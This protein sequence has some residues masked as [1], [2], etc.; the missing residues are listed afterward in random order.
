PGHGAVLPLQALG[1]DGMD[2]VLD[3][4]DDLLPSGWRRHPRSGPLG[5]GDESRGPAGHRT[6]PPP[7]RAVHAP[8]RTLPGPLAGVVL[9]PSDGM[10]GVGAADRDRSGELARRAFESRGG[11]RQADEDVRETG[12]DLAEFSAVLAA[13]ARAEGREPHPSPGGLRP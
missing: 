12:E 1:T 6:N 13:R 5:V 8:A 4:A 9:G 2:D 3:S 7:A 10:G 11:R